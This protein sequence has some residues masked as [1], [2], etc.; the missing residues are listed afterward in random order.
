[1]AREPHAYKAYYP[2]R[3]WSEAIPGLAFLILVI[4]YLGSA[5]FRERRIVAAIVGGVL[6]LGWACAAKFERIVALRVNSAGIT[7]R[8]REWEKKTTATLPWNDIEYLVIWHDETTTSL[9]VQ[10]HGGTAQPTRMPRLMPEPKN[11]V[12]I[13]AKGLDE[14]RLLSA[15]ARYGPTVQI[16][17]GNTGSPV[18]G[19]PYGHRARHISRR[20]RSQELTQMWRNNL[21]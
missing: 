21:R 6:L 16:V 11:C 9:S 12:T 7:V 2:L 1:M 18:T 3:Y 17:D 14:Q 8:L 15:V 13:K 20:S 4:F 19:S 10:P 5:P